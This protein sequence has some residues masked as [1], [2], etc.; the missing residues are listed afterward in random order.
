LAGSWMP[1]SWMTISSL[2]W[3]A[4]F[5]EDTPIWLTRLTMTFWA[6]CIMSIHE[7]SANAAA[8]EIAKLGSTI[9]VHGDVSIEAD[10]R[11][12]VE[13][14]VSAFGR[15]DIMVN[16]AGVIAVDSVIDTSVDDLSRVPRGCSPDDSAG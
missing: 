2:P 7:E 6:V 15:L 13:R 8:R 12:C 9:A 16:N 10:V 5:G 14:T 3:V 4:T 1:A 11:T